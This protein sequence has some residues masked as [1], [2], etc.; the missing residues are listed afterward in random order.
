V[1]WYHRG[2]VGLVRA[3]DTSTPS[4]Q[5]CLPHVQQRPYPA[6][7]PS[8]VKR[9][10]VSITVSLRTTMQA[11]CGQRASLTIPILHAHR[12]VPQD[13]LMTSQEHGQQVADRP[14]RHEMPLPGAMPAFWHL[15]VKAR[16]ESDRASTAAHVATQ[17][18]V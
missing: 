6:T 13:M 17:C 14:Y 1:V 8:G 10:D 12:V 2:G 9:Y 3:D 15:I 7:P 11:P 4:L 5:R 16:H 18:G